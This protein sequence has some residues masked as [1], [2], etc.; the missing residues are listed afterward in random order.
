MA[1]LTFAQPELIKAAVVKYGA[2]SFLFNAM[3]GSTEDPDDSGFTYWYDNYFY[4]RRKTP[5]AATLSR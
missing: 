3:T 1:E 2:V 4:S 5:G